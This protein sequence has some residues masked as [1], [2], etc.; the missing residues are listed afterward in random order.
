MRPVRSVRQ[1]YF[2]FF[3]GI[4]SGLSLFVIFLSKIKNLKLSLNIFKLL[5]LTSYC[6]DFHGS[7]LK[8]K[9]R[10]CV[11]RKQNYIVY[12]CVK[13]ELKIAIQVNL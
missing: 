2:S 6:S 8:K 3:G 4:H 13:E 7:I 11:Q 10:H 1:F 5:I 12:L 9:C